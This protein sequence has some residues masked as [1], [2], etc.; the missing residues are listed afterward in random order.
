M[1][2]STVE[3]CSTCTAVVTTSS[4]PAGRMPITTPAGTFGE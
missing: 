3:P 2:K 4:R 1:I